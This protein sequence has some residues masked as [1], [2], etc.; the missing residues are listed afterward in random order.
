MRNK[1]SSPAEPDGRESV[2][3]FAVTFAIEFFISC[4][5]LRILL[6][7]FGGRGVT[8][9]CVGDCLLAVGASFGIE[10]IPF[11]IEQVTPW[12]KRTWHKPL[13]HSRHRTMVF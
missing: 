7:R 8:Q 4:M 13:H 2:H 5:D 12:K 1:S 9:P 11:T 10:Y 6:M 3:R